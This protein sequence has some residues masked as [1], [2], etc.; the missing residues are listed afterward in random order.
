MVRSYQVKHL[1]TSV[2]EASELAV[3]IVESLENQITKPPRLLFKLG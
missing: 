3:P 1:V 2:L